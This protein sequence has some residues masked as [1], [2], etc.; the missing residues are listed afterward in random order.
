MEKKTLS[1]A[2]GFFF[3][4]MVLFTLLSR[5]AY[6]RGT[7]V[8]QTA[9][10]ARGTIDHTVR[11]NGKTTQNQEI[12][13]T[14]QPGLRIGAVLASEGQQV[15]AGD[16]LFRL[17]MDYLEEKIETQDQELRKQQL[18]VQ[19]AWS[20][21]SAQAR[22]RDTAKA[23]AEENYNAA[24]SGAELARDQAQNAVAQAQKALDDYYAGVSGDA[25]KK[26]ALERAA[27]EA[28]EKL[29][30]AQDDLDALLQER[31]NAVTE[32]ITQADTGEEPLSQ[33]EKDA[34]AAQ[35]EADFAPRV[36]TA[37]EVL[38]QAQSEK[39]RTR[40]ELADFTPGAQQSEQALLDDLEKAEAAYAQA[41]TDLENTA[42]AYGQALE[43]A[44]LPE[45]TGSSAQIGQIT[46]AQML[47]QLQKLEALQNA[48]GEILAPVD[49]VVTASY[50]RTGQLTT[51]TTAFLLADSSQGWRFTAEVTQEQSKYIGTGDQVTLRL[52]SSGKEYKE[53][54][55][56]AFSAKENGGTLTVDL[57][58][59]DIPLGAGM[60]LHFTRRSQAYACCV[61]LSALHMDAQNRAY[62]LTL[63]T[64]NT[65]LGTQTKAA[66]V[67]V[68]VLDKNEKTAALEEGG[69]ADKQIIVSADRAVDSG[70]RVRA[71]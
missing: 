56:I 40:Q 59:A 24:V 32:A 16:V 5:A 19:D 29:T 62:V 17:D 23:Q 37:Q 65:V 69:L 36:Q 30:Q 66:K 9:A 2:L 12:A 54:P 57:P 70:S 21:S 14:T 52:E 33:A 1:K 11:L 43:T 8:V 27:Q 53:L 41:Q 48:D 18:S 15:K 64:V 10:P 20:Q 46:Y 44:F 58:A 34:I 38:A 25:E 50:V 63:E 47:L 22:R 42:R 6:Q 67:M 28:E 13:V 55:V 51:E 3:G 61:P 7:A 71:E 45:S 60:E 31:Q 39:D 26:A 4:G 68:T 49:G 35:I